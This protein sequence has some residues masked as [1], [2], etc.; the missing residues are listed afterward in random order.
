VEKDWNRTI[1]IDTLDV[2]TTEFDISSQK[3]QSLLI[4]GKECTEKYF[5][6]RE[7]NNIWNQLPV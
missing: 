5:K 6:W 4:S 3:I 7:G 1:F 2:R